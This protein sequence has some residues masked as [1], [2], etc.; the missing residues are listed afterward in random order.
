MP[1]GRLADARRRAAD[2]RSRRLHIRWNYC[3]RPKGGGSWGN[4]GFPHVLQPVNVQAMLLALSLR[5]FVA[6][7]AADGS[8]PE[9]IPQCSQRGSFPG[10]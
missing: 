7:N 4:Q 9:W 10:P 1:G 3:R 8:K 6:S 2:D 5:L